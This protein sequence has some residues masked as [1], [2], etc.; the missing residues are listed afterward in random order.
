MPFLTTIVH[1]SVLHVSYTIIPG[2][3]PYPVKPKA[4]YAFFDSLVA[5]MFGLSIGGLGANSIP[6]LMIANGILVM[7]YLLFCY[8]YYTLIAEIR[9]GKRSE[10][11]GAPLRMSG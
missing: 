5:A 2:F 7:C 8:K 10:A 1:L 9:T 4:L 3:V 11:T 6:L